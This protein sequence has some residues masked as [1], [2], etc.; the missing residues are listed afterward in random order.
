M[1]RALALTAA[2][3]FMS[4]GLAE[5]GELGFEKTSE[6]IA[7]ALLSPA[8]LP[9]DEFKT[10]GLSETA[11]PAEFKV[12]GITVVERKQGQTEVVEGLI[13]VPSERTGGFVNLAVRFDVGSYSIRS[14]SMQLLDELGGALRMSDL[15]DRIVSINGHTDFDGEEDFNLRLSLNRALAVKQ[16][17]EN[18]HAISSERLKIMGYGEGLPLVPNISAANKQLNR[19][20]E[21]VVVN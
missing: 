18:N 3:M 17:L 4:I 11:T 16:Y 7:R 2:F 8:N 20:V 9:S 12:R 14:N 19:R 6:G 21:I 15:R 1:I 13:T 10:C 5:A